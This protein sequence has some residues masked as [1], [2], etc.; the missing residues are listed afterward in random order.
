MVFSFYLSLQ[1][2]V[3][4]QILV[5]SPNVFLEFFPSKWKKYLTAL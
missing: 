4:L 5:P 3:L 1:A 2:A